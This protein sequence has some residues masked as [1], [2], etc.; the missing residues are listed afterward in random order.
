MQTL[1]VGEYVRFGSDRK[2]FCVL[3]I[4]GEQIQYSDPLGIYAPTWIPTWC[5][6]HMSNLPHKVSQAD[7]GQEIFRYRLTGTPP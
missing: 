4:V 1:C 7:V 3:K 2:I 5:L 6:F